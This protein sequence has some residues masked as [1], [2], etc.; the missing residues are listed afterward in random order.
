LFHIPALPGEAGEKIKE[1]LEKI[2]RDATNVKEVTN[3][4]L[5]EEFCCAAVQ[6][7]LSAF[8]Y[9]PEALKTE[10]LCLVAK[11]R[12]TTMHYNRHLANS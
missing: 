12:P 9:I 6:G 1:R 3:E 10:E 7:N 2:I 4:L 5:T 11:N 8:Q